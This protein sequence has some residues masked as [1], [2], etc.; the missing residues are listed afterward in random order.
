[1][2]SVKE[3]FLHI[4]QACYNNG[5]LFAAFLIPVIL[6]MMAYIVFGVYPFGSRSVLSL[7][8]N[9]Q[10]IYYY[11]YIH[12]VIGNGESLFYSWSRNLSGE[13]M[14]IIGY[15]LASPLNIIMWLFP[16]EMILEG[17]LLTFLVKFGICGTTFAFFLHKS[18][19]ISK[20]T[21]VIFAPF[22]AMCAYMVVQTMNP[23]WLDGVF[24]LPLVCYGIESLVREYRFRLLIGSLIYAFVSNFYIGF[25]IAIFTVLYFIYCYFSFARYDKAS[26]VITGFIKKG[27]F[28]G[29]CGI[30]AALSSC[31]MLLPVYNSLQNGKLTFTEPDYSLNTNFDFLDVAQKLFPNSYD[32]VN[33][34][35]LP[36]IYCGSLT[37]ILAAVFF[38]CRKIKPAQ[39][40]GIGFLLGALLLCMYIRPVDMLWHGGQFPNWLSYRYSFMVSFILV[41]IAA[42][43][44]EQLKSVRPK[45]IGIIT[46]CYIG[47]I[48]YIDNQD[49][50]STVLGNSGREL[51]DGVTVAIPAIIFI[52]IA[53][54]VC[55]AVRKSAPNKLSKSMVIILV[56]VV[57]G[58]LCFNTTNTLT[59]MDKDIVFS[60]R[61]SYL[62]V[63]LPLREKVEEIK[64][65]DDGFYR[66]EKNF[67][68]TVNDPIAVNMYGLS[69]SSS[70][71]NAKSIE[72]LGYFGFTANSHYTRF[73]GNTPLSC[74]I[75]GVKYIMNTANNAT[76][77]IKSADSITVT[78]NEDALPI[79]FLTDMSVEKTEL[80]KQEVF[81][82]Q[83]LLLS[84]MLGKNVTQSYFE[85]FACDYGPIAEN[86]TQGSFEG[87]HIGFKDAATDAS[88][89]YE[90]TAPDGG[91]IYVY[92]PTDYEREVNLYV[93]D[94]YIGA[95]FESDNQ[96]IKHLGTF[97]KG[98]VFTVKLKLN[99]SDLYYKEPQF[100]FFNA[101]AEEEAI[102]QLQA[103]NRQTV[104]ERVSGTE[105]RVSVNAEKEQLLFTTIPYEKG[106][107]VYVDGVQ[108]EITPVLSDS[109][110][111]VKL[112]A[113]EH[114]VELKFFPAGMSVGLL[115][116]AVGVILFVGMILLYLYLKKPVKITADKL[117]INAEEIIPADTIGSDGEVISDNAADNS[118]END[119]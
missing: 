63:I 103:L 102:A 61:G 3:K 28:M 9:A 58:E 88:V 45:T 5:Y 87:G 13:F 6:M 53:G 116:T 37:L 90:L 75:F 38:C 100:A 20:I 29:L 73:S 112:G 114:I 18:R 78:E 10:Y 72:L 89:T 54:I 81:E 11:D 110:I 49:T 66:I 74:D 42:E 64:A 101:A 48:F 17:L 95:C 104:C 19:G 43:G 79:A 106:W 22:Y 32:T 93:D 99:K 70:T 31:F 118:G 47:L 25:M 8:L 2:Q 62:D 39:R 119:E 24:I 36:F 105:V 41:M 91:D 30:T 97:E 44:F 69:H 1:M 33:V 12:D 60:S 108:T 92:F 71:L 23:M 94:R 107:T 98:E 15:Y 16:R 96:N 65:G 113:G 51:F 14:G 85:L 55:G 117:K 82:N 46:V 109:L 50:F 111:A 115:M 59:K 52:V 83:N 7:D 34:S 21:A 57:S 56:A 77:D 68:R 35:G 26:V 4:R 86:C 27:S 67:F 84:Q 80:V 76:S 40:L